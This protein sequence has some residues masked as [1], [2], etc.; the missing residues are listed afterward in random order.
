RVAANTFNSRVDE[1]PGKD[2]EISKMKHKITE[3]KLQ[4]DQKHEREKLLVQ[5]NEELR[6]KERTS[7]ALSES[8]RTQVDV[9]QFRLG[10]SNEN[11]SEDGPI[12]ELNAREGGFDQSAYF[13]PVRMRKNRVD[14]SEERPYSYTLP[15]SARGSQSRNSDDSM[16]RSVIGMYSANRAQTKV[17]ALDRDVIYA[18][19]QILTSNPRKLSFDDEEKESKGGQT[20]SGIGI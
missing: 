13:T 9:L 11:E 1:I 8:F 5:Q 20:D 16:T 7:F 18:P 3:L 10:L 19:D 2:L 12:M 14:S 17:S 4:L 6:R 15:S